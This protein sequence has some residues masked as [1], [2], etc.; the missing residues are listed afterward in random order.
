MTP[1]MRRAL[2]LA[3]RSLGSTSPNP[4]VGAVIVKD[5][6]IVAEG[7][8]RPPPGPHAEVVALSK[9]GAAARGA[10]L[11]V[12]L[13]PCA[14][15]GRTPPCTESIL[16]A[17]ISE[18][19]FSV[20]DPDPQVNGKGKAALEA[21]GVKVMAGDSEEEASKLLEAYIK[22]RRTGLPFV[23]A[24]FAA[25]LDGRI[26]AASGDSRWVSSPQSLAWSHRLRMQVD[27]IAVGSGTVLADNP[28]L[29]ARPRGKTAKR[30]LLRVV[31][32]SR[33]RIPASAQVLNSDAPTLVATTEE[34]PVKWRKAMQASGAEV[35]LLPIQG[36]HVDSL[37]LLRELGQRGVLS[38]LLE[39]G[40]VLLGDFFDRQLVDKVH[41]IIAPMII[42]AA[43]A[44]TPVSG[45]GAQRMAD[46]LRLREVSLRRLGPDILVSGYPDKGR[47]R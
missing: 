23:I 2:Q 5:G 25:S 32:D 47:P 40:G 43:E 30:Q 17:G 28:L 33:G 20:L 9:A 45:K 11:Y 22:H 13:E 1:Y 7:A 31:L 8:T 3:R 14:H 38:L 12:S 21:G 46:A 37:Q 29:T 10:A 24:K 4:A 42:G 18:V 16:A 36:K 39:G 44:A 26:A 35:L 27:A 19:H 41:A 34:S 6:R 15:H